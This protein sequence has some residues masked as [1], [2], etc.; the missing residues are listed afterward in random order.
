MDSLQPLP[1][2]LRRTQGHCQGRSGREALGEGTL[3]SQH[4]ELLEPR[5][6]ILVDPSDVVA[7][8]LPGGEG[9]KRRW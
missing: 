4:P 1:G 2:A 5:E 8:E 9:E 3:Y 7:V 6:V